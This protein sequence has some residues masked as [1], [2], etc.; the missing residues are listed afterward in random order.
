ME[1]TGFL[2]GNTICLKGRLITL[3]KPFSGQW[4]LMLPFLVV[5]SIKMQNALKLN[6]NLQSAQTMCVLRCPL[7]MMHDA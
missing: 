3:L 6:I 7:V 1:I 4:L 2:N 5:S